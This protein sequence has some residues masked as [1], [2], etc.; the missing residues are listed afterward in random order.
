M[1]MTVQRD[2]EIEPDEVLLFAGGIIPLI[3]GVS[4]G[5]IGLKISFIGGGLLMVASW[6]ILFLLPRKF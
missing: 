3:A 5:L 2:R 4:T 1:K 6:A